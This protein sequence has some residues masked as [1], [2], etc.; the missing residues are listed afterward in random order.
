MKSQSFCHAA[1]CH[2]VLHFCLVDVGVDGPVL[3]GW[4]AVTEWR[5]QDF[6][7]A[8]RQEILSESPWPVQI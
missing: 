2:L 7:G 5:L 3:I 8:Q 1:S 6:L 4:K